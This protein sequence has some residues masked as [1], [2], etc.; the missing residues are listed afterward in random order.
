MDSC[1]SFVKYFGAGLAF[2]ASLLLV[3][4]GGGTTTGNS[5]T[6]PSWQYT[7]LGDSL[8]DGLIAQQGYVPRYATY[9]NL[10]T[11][12]NVTTT[13]L[14]VPG[15]HSGDLL[16]AIQNDTDTRNNIT[17]AQV[18]TWDIGGDDLANAHDN[19]TKGTCGGA[20]NQDCLRNAVATFEQNWN[21]IISNI[22]KLRTT[23]NTIIRTMD[24]YNP[25]VASDMQA[26]IFDTVEPYLDEVNNY[27][28]S[29]ASANN[30]PVANVHQAFNGADGKTDP[31]TLGL[32]ALDGFHPNDAG[33]KV[34]ADQLRALQYAPLH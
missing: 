18:L 29:T 27:I 17:D 14:G 10:D 26:G 23:S 15:W 11:G 3:A 34:I 6:A 24:I 28:H 5:P 4:C 32:I 33:H 25:Y 20:D 7:A 21:A 13:N 19:F 22:L 16:N 2:G 30:I 31:G 1:F 9:V 12:A 8:A